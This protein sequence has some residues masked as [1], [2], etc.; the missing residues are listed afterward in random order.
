MNRLFHYFFA[1]F[2]S[3]IILFTLTACS[4]ETQHWHATRIEGIMPDLAFS[5]TDQD[6]NNVTEKNYQGKINIL[7]FGYTNCP[8]VC[9]Y[10]L[11]KLAAVLHQLPATKQQQVN[12]LFVSVDPSRD[13][14]TIR[15]QYCAAFSPEFY[16]LSGTQ[17]QLKKLNR[18][19]RVTFGYGKPDATG[20]YVVYHSSAMYIFDRKNHARLLAKGTEKI[21]EL[22]EDLGKL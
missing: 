19:Y 16:G 6:N 8:D 10:T 18:R 22:A 13:T 12:V 7:F 4:Q 2:F 9:P 3:S 20:N 5:L 11:G 14:P 21:T 1:A 17:A 15:K